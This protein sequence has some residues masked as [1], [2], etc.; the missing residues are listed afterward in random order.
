[1][2]NKDIEQ[3][4]E[5]ILALTRSIMNNCYVL[6]GKVPRKCKSVDEYVQFD[7][8]NLKRIARSHRMGSTVSTV[9]LMHDHNWHSDGLPILF[10][11]MVFGGDMDPVPGK[12][13]VL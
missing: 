3:A 11:T 6:E 10:E 9:F 8:P 13:F 4:K 7:R 12:V 5:N 1:M 2:T